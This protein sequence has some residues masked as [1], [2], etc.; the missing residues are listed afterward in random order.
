MQDI[1]GK[2]DKWGDTGKFDPFDEIFDVSDS[3]GT[4]VFSG[5]PSE[6]PFPAHF[7]HDC[8]IGHVR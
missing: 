1:I 6:F 2:V 3:L 8:P 4:Y 7:P 5:S